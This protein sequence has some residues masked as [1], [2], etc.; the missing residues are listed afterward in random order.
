MLGVPL[1]NPNVLTIIYL[2]ISLKCI[3]QRNISWQSGFLSR[4]PNMVAF[5]NF[6]LIFSIILQHGFTS[7][8]SRTEAV[9]I[10]EQLGYGVKRAVYYLNTL[11]EKC[12]NVEDL[13]RWILFMDVCIPEPFH[14]HLILLIEHKMKRETK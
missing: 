11:L 12:D 3:W 1:I 5:L 2:I 8:A 4:L 13:N 10:A 14:Y 7:L 9:S 6:L